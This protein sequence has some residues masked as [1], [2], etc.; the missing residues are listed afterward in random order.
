MTQEESYVKWKQQQLLKIEK[1]STGKQYIDRNI[2]KNYS[3]FKNETCERCSISK[4]AC[5]FYIREGKNGMTLQKPCKDC[6][7]LY[8]KS[9]K[10]IIRGGNLKRVF[11]LSR[12]EY[13]AIL[14]E[15]E[16]RCK[17]CKKHVSEF[18]KELAVDHCHKTNK[19]RG[20]LCSSCN[21]GI[22]HFKDNVELM[23]EGIKYLQ[24]SKLKDN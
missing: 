18:T 23:N 14:L 10:E 2:Y 8:Q 3:P 12:E 24:N 16:E 22:G 20:L 13:N 9:R 6:M 4:P 21:T 1:Y 5:E 7:R 11:N 17:I 15:Q 19:V